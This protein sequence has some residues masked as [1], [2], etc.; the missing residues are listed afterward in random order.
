MTLQEPKIFRT[1]QYVLGHHTGYI[2]DCER[3]FKNDCTIEDFRSRRS[4]CHDADEDQDALNEMSDL[5]NTCF[6]CDWC[7]NENA[8]LV[9][10]K[11]PCWGDGN[12][13]KNEQ[14]PFSKEVERIKRRNHY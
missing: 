10:G 13:C 5:V 1:R 4:K 14:G 8:S 9:N 2:K 11:M 6:K 12:F 7:D 3:S